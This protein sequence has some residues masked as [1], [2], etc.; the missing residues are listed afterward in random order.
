MKRF[1]HVTYKAIE[2]LH[3]LTFRKYLL[4]VPFNVHVFHT[5]LLEISI[6]SFFFFFCSVGL[7]FTLDPF[8]FFVPKQ[9]P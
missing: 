3:C 9:I 8:N 7:F 4:N 2:N 5:P 1:A 6:S